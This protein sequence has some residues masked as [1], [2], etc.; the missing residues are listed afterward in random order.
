MSE[1]R[2][3]TETFSV[4]VSADEA[5]AIRAKAADAGVTP[6]ALFR[7]AAL[8][9]RLPTPPRELLSGIANLGRLGGLLKL[10]LTQIDQG[11]MPAD[12]RQQ[13]DATLT[14]IRRA[15]DKVR[16]RLE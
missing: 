13:V 8:E 15:A 7:A 14:A 12:L 11:K 16:K 3:R 5:T 6:S 4:R 9:R 10:A 1:N 2:Q